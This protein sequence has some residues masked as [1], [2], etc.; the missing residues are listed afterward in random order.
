MKVYRIKGINDDE[1]TCHCCG[2]TNLKRVVWLVELD[3]DGNEIG[4]AFPYGTTCASKAMGWRETSKAKIEKRQA[5]EVAKEIERQKSELFAKF[6]K[7]G[8]NMLPRDLAIAVQDGEMSIND[9]VIERNKR[10]PVLGA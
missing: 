4:D 2:K 5:A 3:A 9:A 8:Y 7:V 1:D 6:V 10:Y